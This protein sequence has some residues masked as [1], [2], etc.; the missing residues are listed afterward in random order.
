MKK[1]VVFGSVATF[2]LFDVVNNKNWKLS[3]RVINSSF[4]SQFT[5]KK[6]NFNRSNLSQLSPS[7]IDILEADLLKVFYEHIDAIN[8]D[9]ILIDFNNERFPLV[10]FKEGSYATYST[11]IKKSNL[12]RG[13]DYIIVDPMTQE[14]FEVWAACWDSF[15]NKIRSKNMLERT[16]INKIFWSDSINNKDVAFGELYGEELIY[17]MNVFLYKLYAYC[18]KDLPAENF[19]SYPQGVLVAD[20]NHKWGVTPFHYD[21]QVYHY[22]EKSLLSEIE[23]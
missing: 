4:A 12:L 1:I 17:N 5:N 13:R 6:V 11:E 22:L 21:R 19:L 16:F 7:Q 10:K 20:A 14:Y 18:S 23:S 8:P 9:V 15:M 2:G 3:K